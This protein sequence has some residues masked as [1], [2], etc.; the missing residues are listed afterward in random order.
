[1]NSN[2]TAR[3]EKG[4][5]YSDII[6]DRAKHLIIAAKQNGV[7]HDLDDT[8]SE[9]GEVELINIY[10]D[11]GLKI[12]RHS[13][14]HLL[15]NAI[16][17]LYPG[18][19]PNTSN[20]DSDVF[21]YDFDM[22]PISVDDFPK[23]EEKMREIASK[24]L[25][26]E[27]IR[28]DKN[29]MLEIFKDNPYKIDKINENLKDGEISN[30][31][32]QG[33]Y[34]EF[35]RGPHVPST[36]YIKAFKLLSVA[37][38]NYEGDINKQKM[39]RIY[40]T[41]FPDQK[42]LK[43]F[44]Q[45]R[46]EAMKRDHRKIGQEMDLFLFDERA[47]G[48][49]F[50]TPN[51]AIIRNELINYMRELNEKNGWEDV[52]TPHAYRD[53]IWKESGH[54]DKYKNDMFLFK[55]SNGDD[56]GLKP[57]NCPG[58]IAI[59]QRSVHSYREMPIK[60]SEA[61]TVYRYEKSGEMGGLT[62]PRAFTIDDGHGFL[63][64]D[65]IFDEV[66]SLIKIIPDVFRTIMGESEISYD[67]STIDKSNPQNY[68]LSYICRDCGEKFEMRAASGV[69]KC[70][71]CGST[72]LEVDF[73]MWDNATDNLRSALEDLN[74]KYKEN[75]GDA[76]FYGPKIDIH[77]KDALGRFWQLSTIQLDFFMPINF[78]LTYVDSDGKKSRPVILHRAIY[79]SYERFI[80]ILL[81]HFNG[82]MPTWLSPVQTYVVPVSENYNDYAS[83]V[84]SELVK[85]HI[86]SKLDLSGN[87]I[88]KK[89]KL[90][91][92]M[93][94]SYIIVVGEKEKISNTVSVRNR[95]DKTRSYNLQDFISEINMEIK[96]R[97]ID[98]L[99]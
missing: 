31:Y 50:Y 87:T 54:Y 55:L 84:H 43:D 80:A 92:P 5:R 47:P 9:S 21:Y 4:Q 72:N 13:T 51:G 42:M 29:A 39:V 91:R 60:Y 56:Y 30:I 49:P 26:I 90:I 76:A 89:I 27:K 82:K 28:Q 83:Y 48:F 61:G 78:D 63:R 96:N 41:S 8:A 68:L 22:P 57:M 99:F 85:N 36:G 77:V 67:L 17:D 98:Q 37:S 74:L 15:A 3:I 44:L 19:K 52:W 64:P 35:C 97:S 11:D 24:N 88:S 93:R 1:M 53:I 10:S 81:E 2:I 75:P 25:K 14:A 12:L 59:Y 94:V 79:G 20:E 45:R 86:R 73:S 38:T 66:S 16:V 7:L 18:A 34:I 58:H 32:R 71:K 40:G 95:K 46:E 33:N 23:I 69:L 70:P 6:S 65:Q 62:R